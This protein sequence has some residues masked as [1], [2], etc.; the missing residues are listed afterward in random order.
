MPIWLQS[1]CGVCLLHSVLHPF[2]LFSTFNICWN[3][4]DLLKM[5]NDFK[6]SLFL[7]KISSFLSDSYS[8]YTRTIKIF[9]TYTRLRSTNLVLC[10]QYLYH[11]SVLWFFS[12][13]VPLNWNF[14]VVTSLLL[15][16][17]FHRQWMLIVI[18][19]LLIFSGRK[20]IWVIKLNGVIYTQ[21]CCILFDYRCRGWI[22]IF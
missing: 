9:D 10:K 18:V 8:G 6:N 13:L 15:L 1:R 5:N 17:N 2:C 3:S 12:L 21:K 20:Y 4:C 14:F 19:P 22:D 16:I 7:L 11:N